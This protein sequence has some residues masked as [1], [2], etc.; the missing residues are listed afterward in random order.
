MRPLPSPVC[1]AC[2]AWPGMPSAAADRACGDACLLSRFT[3]FSRNICA[4]LRS[5]KISPG[6]R[7]PQLPQLRRISMVEGQQVP[8]HALGPRDAAFPNALIRPSGLGL[9][10]PCSLRA[11]G[12]ARRRFT[13]RRHSTRTSEPG[14]LRELRTWPQYA[15]IAIASPAWVAYGLLPWCLSASQP[16]RRTLVPCWHSPAVRALPHAAALPRRSASPCG[17]ARPRLMH[18]PRSDSCAAA[19]ALAHAAVLRRRPSS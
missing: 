5:R 11:C 6:F 1:G 14:T 7:Q 3:H 8:A 4:L 12:S 15:L 9:M 16:S 19:I 13:G 2:V 10:R 18:L 17:S